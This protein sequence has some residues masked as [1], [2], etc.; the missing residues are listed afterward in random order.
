MWPDIGGVAVG[1]TLVVDAALG[2]LRRVA[3]GVGVLVWVGVGVG[4]LGVGVAVGRRVAVGEGVLLA[5]G[6]AVGRLVAVAGMGVAVGWAVASS[7]CVV[8]LATATSP[9]GFCHQS[10]FQPKISRALATSRRPT[11]MMTRQVA[12]GNR[13]SVSLV[14]DGVLAAPGRALAVSLSTGVP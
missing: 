10:V 12:K 11:K 6:V 4:V 14:A 8:R 1:W 13:R 7:A 3:V 2:A 5:V 9:D